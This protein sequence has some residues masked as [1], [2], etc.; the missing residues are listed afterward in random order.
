MALRII[1]TGKAP[2][3]APL[4]ADAPKATV[5]DPEAWWEEHNVAP[6]AKRKTCPFCQGSFLTPC[7]EREHARCQNFQAVQKRKANVS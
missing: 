5:D 6:N 2:E 4:V 3:A 1:K 7:K